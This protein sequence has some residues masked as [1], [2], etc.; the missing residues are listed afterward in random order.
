[1]MLEIQPLETSKPKVATRWRKAG[2]PIQSP[3][4]ILP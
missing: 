3:M 1:M 2:W 4:L